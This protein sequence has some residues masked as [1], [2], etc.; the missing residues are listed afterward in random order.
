MRGSEGPEN[1]AD[2][3]RKSGKISSGKMFVV[4]EGNEGECRMRKRWAETGATSA[5]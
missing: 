5:S 1:I 4:S 3:A 2:D